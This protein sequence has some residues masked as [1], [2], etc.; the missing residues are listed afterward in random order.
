[1]CV[2]PLSRRLVSSHL[3]PGPPASRSRANPDLDT[4]PPIAPSRATAIIRTASAGSECNDDASAFRRI[5]RDV[6]RRP[7]HSS[8]TISRDLRKVPHRRIG[9]VTNCTRG[10][11]ERAQARPAVRRG[12]RVRCVI[13][14]SQ[15]VRRMPPRTLRPVYPPMRNDNVC[16]RH[17]EARYRMLTSSR[18]A[19]ADRLLALAQEDVN[20]RWGVYEDL[21][22]RWPAPARRASDQ[23]VASR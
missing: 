20:H 14:R 3:G 15:G 6:V 23:G 19:E 7:G 12:W 10:G 1:M 22:R 18:P 16:R 11:P 9:A 21:A 2:S 4:S 5:L 17:N 8:R 13:N